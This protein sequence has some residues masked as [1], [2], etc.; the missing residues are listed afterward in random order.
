[1]SL[2]TLQQQ[3]DSHCLCLSVCLSQSLSL[4][5][6]PPRKDEQVLKEHLLISRGELGEHIVGNPILEADRRSK[7]ES[8]N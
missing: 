8:K 5:H 6:P 1:M 3:A 4:S 2:C 7:G